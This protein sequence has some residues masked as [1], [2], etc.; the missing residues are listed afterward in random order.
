MHAYPHSA[1]SHARVCRRRR[2]YNHLAAVDEGSASLW[3]SF[4]LSALSDTVDPLIT[5]EPPQELLLQLGVVFDKEE[6]EAEE[7][8][9]VTP[10]SVSPAAVPEPKREVSSPV[11]SE[12]EVNV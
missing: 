2:F 6:E 8:V 3:H 12:V 7:D 9:D 10:A 5:E 11:L 4:G 1:R